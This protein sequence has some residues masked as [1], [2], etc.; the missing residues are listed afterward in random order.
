MLAEHAV[1]H[2]LLVVLVL[3]GFYL[4]LQRTPLRIQSEHVPDGV[5]DDSSL[6]QFRRDGVD[7]RAVTAFDLKHVL[8][9][10]R[11]EQALA[12][13]AGNDKHSLAELPLPVFRIDQSEDAGH[14]RL[15]PQLQ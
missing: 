2:Q 6:F 12:I 10:R 11:R 7:L 13:L 1:V 14:K 8:R 15:L 3:T 5:V 9:D 4:L